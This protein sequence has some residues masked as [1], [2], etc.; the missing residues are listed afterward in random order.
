MKK[1][2]VI[3]YGSPHENGHTKKAL[4]KGIKELKNDYD[5][6]FIDAFK[7]NIK[8]CIDCGLCEK[9][10]KCVF[11]DFNDIDKILRECELL[12]V[13]TPIYNS[14][15]PAPLKAIIDRTQLYFN[16]KTKLKI[17]PFK[18]KK[19]A[20]LVATYGSNDDSCEKIILNQLKLFFILLNAK[21]SKAIF[22]K[23]T[24]KIKESI[25]HKVHHKS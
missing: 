15:F 21:L 10:G 25:N 14:S 24:D 6:E 2:A 3:L 23:N 19:R 7:A 22:V 12:I 9:N 16:M 4:N 17:N 13:A 18:Q 1:K 11:S 20:I 8:P 5:F